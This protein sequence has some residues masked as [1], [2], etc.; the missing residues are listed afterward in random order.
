MALALVGSRIVV[1][2]ALIA[3]SFTFSDAMPTK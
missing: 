2:T 3:T 1:E